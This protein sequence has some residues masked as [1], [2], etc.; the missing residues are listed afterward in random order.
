[1]P[2]ILLRQR[3]KEEVGLEK[4]KQRKCIVRFTE[5]PAWEAVIV[6]GPSMV[7]SDSERAQHGQQ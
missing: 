1:M 3:A 4:V 2:S 7:S 5:G 6:R